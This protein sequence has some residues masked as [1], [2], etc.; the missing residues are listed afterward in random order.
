MSENYEQKEHELRNAIDE[1]NSIPYIFESYVEETNTF[2]D[3][4]LDETKEIYTL[5][6]QLQQKENIIKE[7][8]EYIEK[9]IP[10][11]K[12]E[13]GIANIN[14]SISELLNY[15]KILQILDK[16]NK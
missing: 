6:N 1:I 3:R 10:I 7:V 12:A 4:L 14:T 16:E 15:E 2:I 5:K 11:V 8:I 9:Q 13:I